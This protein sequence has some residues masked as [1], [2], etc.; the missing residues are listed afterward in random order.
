M[1]LRRDFCI[2]SAI[3]KHTGNQTMSADIV[4][5]KTFEDEINLIE[6]NLKE[7]IDASKK[8]LVRFTETMD[9]G[10]YADQSLH[11]VL[12]QNLENAHKAYTDFIKLPI[13]GYSLV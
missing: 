12:N 6:K 5:Y 7:N 3:I 2:I 13:S 10:N 4:T 9:Q 1:I 11:Y 8:I